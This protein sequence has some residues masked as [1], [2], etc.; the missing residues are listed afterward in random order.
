MRLGQLAARAQ[1]LHLALGG[2]GAKPDPGW[3]GAQV[4]GDRAQFVGGLR[5]RRLSAQVCEVNNRGKSLV[6]AVCG[7]RPIKHAE[8]QYLSKLF[9]GSGLDF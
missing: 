6:D 3:I 9:V 1:C 4:A 8:A 2:A 5:Q 7:W